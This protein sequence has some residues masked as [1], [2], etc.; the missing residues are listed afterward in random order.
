M[1]TSERTEKNPTLEASTLHSMTHEEA[2]AFVDKVLGPAESFPSLLLSYRL[3]DEFQEPWK[4]EL[5]HWLKAAEVHGFLDQVLHLIEAE[6][7]RPSK[8][9]Y[10]SENDDRHLKLHQHVA[11]CR[12]VHYLAGT[13]WTFDAYEPDVGGKVD[14]D[15]SL[16]APDGGRVEMQ[17]KAPDQP[18]ELRRYREMDGDLVEVA[19]SEHHG[20]E[21]Q[22]ITRRVEGEYNHRIEEA[23]R[24][25]AKQLR[26]DSAGPGLIVVCANR[27][28]P[29]AW[30]PYVVTGFALGGSVGSQGK[31]SLPV[32]RR[33]AF[34]T[35]EWK[36]VSGIVILDFVIGLSGG[37]YPCTIILNPNAAVPASAEWFPHARVLELADDVFRWRN[38]EP[39]HSYFPDGTVLLDSL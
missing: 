18:G 9:T 5:G 28:W 7:K 29:L 8:F 26:P 22:L 24:K 32:A 17:V 39:G 6:A 19:P 36:R 14:I 37:V 21:W 2:I 1:A 31:V 13:G 15:V 10:R 16:N 30:T 35:D 11:V 23:V 34:F 38:G 4:A 3:S 25:A 20:P 27:A 33:G 12:V